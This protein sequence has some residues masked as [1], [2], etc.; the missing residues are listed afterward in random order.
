MRDCISKKDNSN[1][2]SSES[3]LKRWMLNTYSGE[4]AITKM[5]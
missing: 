3:E 5:L 1:L 2:Q 4:E